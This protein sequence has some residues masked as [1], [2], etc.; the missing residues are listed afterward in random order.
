M[1]TINEHI[2]NQDFKNIYLLYGNEAYLQCQYRD[3][4]IKALCPDGDEMNITRFEGKGISVTEVSELADT[5]PFFAERRVIIIEN[6]RWFKKGNKEAEDLLARLPDTTYLR[7]VESEVDGKLK[8]FKTAKQLGYATEMKTPTDGELLKW[9]AVQCKR[10][11]KQMTE[12]AARYLVEQRDMNMNL[13]Q[14]ELEKVLSYTIEADTITLEDVQAL[15]TN[16]VENKIFD[17]LDAIGNRNREAAL[18]IYHGLIEQRQ[19]VMLILSLLNKRIND[20]LQVSEMIGLGMNGAGIEEKTGIRSWA[21]KKY[22]KQIRYFS[23]S[24][25]LEMLEA[26]Q[27]VEVGIKRGLYQDVIGAELLIVEFSSKPET[28]EG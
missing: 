11:G 9:I 5:L 1:K 14:M 27:D 7:F 18:S 13:L 19:P 16:Q 10:E 17:M 21:V 4:L 15:C 28:A 6:S 3:K 26:I 23:Y 24:R 25:L 8:L 22:Q 20:L 2:K 12:S